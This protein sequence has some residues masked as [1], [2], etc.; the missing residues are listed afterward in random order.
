M[1]I[2]G[3]FHGA[4]LLLGELFKQ[5]LPTAEQ[6]IICQPLISKFLE[7]EYCK[8]TFA[9]GSNVRDAACYAVWSLTRF[10]P[11]CISKPIYHRLIL[12]SLFDRE[13]GCRR[14]AAAAFQELVG[15]SEK[16]RIYVDMLQFVNYC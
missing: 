14:A 5:R 16:G 15:R 4:A 10:Q 7:F 6:L 3:T 9:L 2:N 8:G 13:V 1:S 12:M 11:N